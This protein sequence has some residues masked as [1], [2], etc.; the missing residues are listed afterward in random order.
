M[1]RTTLWRIPPDALETPPHG[2]RDRPDRRS[3][4]LLEF[5]RQQRT[6]GVSGT[7]G[8]PV[9]RPIGG[10]IRFAIRGTVRRAARPPL[11]RR[12]ARPSPSPTRRWARPWS[13]A[14]PD[15]VHVHRRTPTASR[16]AM[17]TARPTGR[18]SSRTGPITVGHWPDRNQVRDRQAHGRRPGSGVDEYPLYTFAHD[19]A[20]GDTNG[21]GLRRSLVRGRRG[22]RTDQELTFRLAASSACG[23]VSRSSPATAAFRGRPIARR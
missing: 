14:R 20:P 16:P 19:A 11:P 22:R 7:N 2:A 1:N 15:P 3:R 8:R 10:P 4:R 9:R 17:A 18:R 5:G 12:R 23:A 21:K 6:R 13:T